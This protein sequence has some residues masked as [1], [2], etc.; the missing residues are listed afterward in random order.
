MKKFLL[1]LLFWGG[2]SGVYAQE[3]PPEWVQYTYSG[4]IYD[5]QNDNLRDYNGTETAFKDYLLRIT[6]SK[7]A[8]KV[9]V[10][11][12]TR[13]SMDKSAENGRTNIY[14]RSTSTFSTDVN[15]ELVDFKTKYNP[16]T[17]EGWA[18]AY[19]NKA[20]AKRYY[21]NKVEQIINQAQKAVEICS[22]YVNK[23]FKSKAAE[24][25]KTALPL[26]EE[27]PE[28]FFW[29]NFFGMTQEEQADL[30]NRC[31][32]RENKLKNMVADMKYGTKI[33][34]TAT[35][36]LFGSPYFTLKNELKGVLA[37]EGC[38]FT[39]NPEEADWV[40]GME[41]S[42]REYNM[43]PTGNVVSYFAYVDA[44]LTIDKRVQGRAQRIYED[45]VSVKGGHTH[46]YTEAGRTA[47]KDISKKAGAVITTTLKE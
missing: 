32:S 15:L 5:I 22:D 40:I 17:K 1:A 7:L 28:L 18:I 30:S 24:E 34:L 42:A 41:C 31:A 23:G 14:Y 38:T 29:L 33:Y 19:I 35:A 46:N 20:D 10:Q 37:K 16:A 12:S 3:C 21:G 47:Y 36:D 27:L 13:S 6:Q 2:V 8:E 26:F 45:Q 11:V 25:A 4:Y 43:I 44:L 39:E 9:Q